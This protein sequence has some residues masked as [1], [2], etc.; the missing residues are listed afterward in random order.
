MFSRCLL[1]FPECGDAESEEKPSCAGNPPE[2]WWHCLTDRALG[3]MRA[4]CSL[5]IPSAKC[6]SHRLSTQRDCTVYNLTERAASCFSGILWRNV[7]YSMVQCPRIWPWDCTEQLDWRG[8]RS[9]LNTRAS[10]HTW[11][12]GSGGWNPKRR[13]RRGFKMTMI[14]SSR[15]SFW[16]IDLNVWL[17]CEVLL[18]CDV[19]DDHECCVRCCW[20]VM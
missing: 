8:I 15:D 5:V 4:T 18:S 20:A 3:T 19:S 11:K 2:L 6:H 1:F 16:W 13:S 12:R 10:S 14:K 7:L 17:Q 9:I